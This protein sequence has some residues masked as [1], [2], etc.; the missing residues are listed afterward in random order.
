[1]NYPNSPPSRTSFPIPTHPNHI[2]PPHHSYTNSPPP[3][4]SP[5]Q[6]S[7]SLTPRA[8]I[9][10]SNRPYFPQRHPAYTHH[11]RPA[12]QHNS[13]SPSVNRHFRNTHIQQLDTETP[14]P[15]HYY[16]EHTLCSDPTVDPS[17]APY[18]SHYFETPLPLH[19]TTII[20]LVH[21]MTIPSLNTLPN[22][23]TIHHPLTTLSTQLICPRHLRHQP[24]FN[25]RVH[26]HNATMYPA[27]SLYRRPHHTNT[28]RNPTI[29][30]TIS[31]DSSQYHYSLPPQHTH[32]YPL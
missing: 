3:Q 19:H 5:N 20:T 18:T 22:I 16:T 15:P 2:R 23:P 29:R 28:N 31:T 7:H 26:S 4:H 30:S 6:Y 13:R 8:N 10:H 1:M 32:P 25:N 9:T 24:L 27:D 14:L 12:D 11:T 21:L 17:P